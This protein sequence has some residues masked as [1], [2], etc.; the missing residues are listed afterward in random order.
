MKKYLLSVVACLMLALSLVGC[1]KTHKTM[2]FQEIYESDAVIRSKIDAQVASMKTEEYKD[3]SLK[4]EGNAAIYTFTFN[5]NLAPEYR[6]VFEKMVGNSYNVMCKTNINS[7]RNSSVY[8][9][10]DPI[11]MTVIFNNADGSE[12]YTFTY[13]EGQD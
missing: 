4:Y 5:Q 9:A 1:G 13:T 3:V 12:F 2:T 11:T 6:S 10:E 7:M 8:L